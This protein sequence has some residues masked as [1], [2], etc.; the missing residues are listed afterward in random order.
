MSKGIWAADMLRRH[1]TYPQPTHLDSTLV[2]SHEPLAVLLFRRPS[3]RVT[4]PS[5]MALRIRR[6]RKA[7]GVFFPPP[8]LFPSSP[9]LFP[10]SPSPFLLFPL[11]LFPLYLPPSTLPL[12]LPFLG[13][14]LYLESFHPVHFMVLL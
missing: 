6:S 8:L 14:E 4:L 1:P 12:P 9:L 10:S 7:P 11:F 2:W 3:G 13:E 5:S